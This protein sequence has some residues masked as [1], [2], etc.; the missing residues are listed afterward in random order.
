MV[1][2]IQT[3]LVDH[4]LSK[5]QKMAQETRAMYLTQAHTNADP[6]EQLAATP[7][8]HP[9]KLMDWIPNSV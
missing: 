9:D 5:R 6:W 1:L 7:R 4:G 2:S 3:H 8:T